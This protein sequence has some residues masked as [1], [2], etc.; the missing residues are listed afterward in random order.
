MNFESLEKLPN[1]ESVSDQLRTIVETGSL[2]Q[3][4]RFHDDRFH[5]SGLKDWKIAVNDFASE[6]PDVVSDGYIEFLT[7]VGTL[8]AQS[9][10]TQLNG[11]ESRH[12]KRIGKGIFLMSIMYSR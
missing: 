2:L 11:H 9:G 3:Y 7:M 8:C 1:V 6:H 12:E 10:L 4:G 5:V